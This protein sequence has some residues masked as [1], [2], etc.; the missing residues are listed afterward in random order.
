MGSMGSVMGDGGGHGWQGRGS[1]NPSDVVS[2]DV[3]L[4]LIPA[5]EI[6]RM[7][8][9]V[10]GTNWRARMVLPRT[11]DFWPMLANVA[12]QPGTCGQRRASQCL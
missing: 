3:P 8:Q 11:Q 9:G 5:A 4:D 1:C 2:A 6:L 10:L 12:P 7:D